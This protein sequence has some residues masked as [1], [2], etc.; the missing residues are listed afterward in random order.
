MTEEIDE[1]LRTDLLTP[2]DGFAGRVMERIATLPLPGP[3]AERRRAQ[4]IF[5]WLALAGAVLAGLSQLLA[6]VFGV[7]SVSNAG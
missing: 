7:W 4:D 5:E 2:P 6:F 3:A 1:L